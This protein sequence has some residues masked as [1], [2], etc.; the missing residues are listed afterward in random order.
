MVLLYGKRNETAFGRAGKN[1]ETDSNF[2]IPRQ[3][4][5]WG[6]ISGFSLLSFPP[7]P[8]GEGVMPSPRSRSAATMGQK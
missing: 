3:T 4:S 5:R 2:L 1:V 8:G 7:L 6:E